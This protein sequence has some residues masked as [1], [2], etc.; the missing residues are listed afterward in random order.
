M[1]RKALEEKS[2]KEKRKRGVSDYQ[3]YLMSYMPQFK[4]IVISE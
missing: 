4:N 1:S 2:Q 3:S